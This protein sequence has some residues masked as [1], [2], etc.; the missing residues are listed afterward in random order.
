MAA[1]IALAAAMVAAEAIVIEAFTASDPPGPVS[2]RLVCVR[3]GGGS[4]GPPSLHR[5]GC[6][7]PA[8]RVPAPPC[9][10][11]HLPQWGLHQACMWLR[12]SAST[13]PAKCMVARPM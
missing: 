4:T 13:C 5:F 11:V 8:Q 9:A 3:S 2:S 1:V 10:S 7:L 12:T 6:T